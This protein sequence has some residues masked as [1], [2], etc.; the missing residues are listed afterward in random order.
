MTFRNDLEAYQDLERLLAAAGERPVLIVVDGARPIDQGAAEVLAFVARRL[1]RESMAVVAAESSD[2]ADDRPPAG[3]PTSGLRQGLRARDIEGY[4]AAALMLRPAV[5]AFLAG[6]PGADSEL[7]AMACIAAGELLD[8]DARQVIAT[9]WVRA[10]RD[11]GSPESLLAALTALARAELLGGRLPA[12]ESALAEA[13]RVAVAGAGTSAI[14]EV[15]LSELAVLA[16]RGGEEPAAQAADLLPGAVA[17]GFF[18][19][20]LTVLDLARGR[21]PAAL[22]RALEIMHDDRP[23]HGTHILPDLVEA[24]SRTGDRT[25][26]AAALDRLAERAVAGGTPLA[27]GLLARSRALLAGGRTADGLYGEARA[28]L[29]RTGQTAQVA[30]TRL[31]HGEWLRRRRRNR[32]AREHLTAAADMFEAIEMNAFVQRSQ[33]ELRATG[34]RIGRRGGATGNQLTSQ[35]ARIAQLVAD[36]LTNREIATQLFISSN[37]VEYHLHKVFRK[38][39]VTSRTQLARAVLKGS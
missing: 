24:A 36:G 8:D 29:E 23:D 21:Y 32:D 25:V 18:Q 1:R 17:T 11:R 9:R 31:L 15:R 28:F 22:A 3:A 4:P 30:R 37:T 5:T 20:A 14:A 34:A 33:A 35:E 16:W 7:Y 12:A 2:P 10:E 27:L 19:S 38:F 6:P 39:V 26:A 13:R